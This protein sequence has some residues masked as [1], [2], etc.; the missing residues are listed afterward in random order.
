MAKF[1]K[2]PVEVEAMQWTH[3][4]VIPPAPSHLLRQRRRFAW[5]PLAVG[6]GWELRTLEGWY[7]LNVGD[8]LVRGVVG[9]YHP[10]RSDIF[11][12]TYEPV[13]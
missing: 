7:Q 9:E 11:A 13:E 12:A 3:E 10:V 2:K 8:W 5:S 6:L 4:H 1:R